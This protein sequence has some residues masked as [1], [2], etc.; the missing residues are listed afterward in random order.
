M[1]GKGQR[2]LPLV[3]GKEQGTVL[4]TKKYGL[5]LSSALRRKAEKL[6]QYTVK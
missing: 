5:N 1:V 4:I 3:G 2:K 6:T